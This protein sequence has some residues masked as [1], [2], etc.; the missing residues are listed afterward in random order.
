[1]NRAN[2]DYTVAG[3]VPPDFYAVAADSGVREWISVSGRR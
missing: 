1:M 2:R 3:F